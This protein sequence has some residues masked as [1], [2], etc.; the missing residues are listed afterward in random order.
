MIKKPLYLVII[1]P[2][3]GGKGTQAKLLEKRLGIKHIS[4]GELFREE[5]AK[6]TQLGKKIALVINQGRWMDTPTTLMVLK[7]ALQKSLFSGFILDG[8]PRAPD[9]PKALDAILVKEGVELDLVIH[10]QVGVEEIM[11]RRQNL[12]NQ[13][14]GFYPG[15]NRKDE[16]LE[17]IQGRLSA[18][19]KTIKPILL[20]Y[21]R[22]GILAEV[23]GERK[24][25]PIHQEILGLIKK[26]VDKNGSKD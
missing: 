12:I 9:Q 14:K 22:K 11:E 1:G 4:T 7:Q 5:I 17:A 2:S 20:Y 3:G 26:S 8:F 23:D 18:Y 19:Q 15:Q 10:L 13:G 25:K 6:K 16:S 21:H 24:V